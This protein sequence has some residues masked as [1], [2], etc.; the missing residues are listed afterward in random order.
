MLESLFSSR[1]LK[2]PSQLLILLLGVYLDTPPP[3][4]HAPAPIAN[5]VTAPKLDDIKTEY[6]PHS[7]K[8]SQTSS[9]EEYGHRTVP[10]PP[11]IDEEPWKP[12]R[13]R[14]DFELAEFAV[15]SALTDDKVNTLISLFKRAQGAESV[16]LKSYTEMYDL[17]KSK[18]NTLTNVSR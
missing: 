12:F 11:P 16:T 10:L 1:T 13:C 15:Q 4:S 8:P 7:G 17:L 3:S 5:P 9:F 18:A 6:H 2:V 14:L